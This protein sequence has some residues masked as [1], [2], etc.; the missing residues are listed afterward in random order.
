MCYLNVGRGHLFQI[1][2]PHD[3]DR[4]IHDSFRGEPIRR[5]I[6]PSKNVVW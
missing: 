1:L 2:T 6:L 5:T 4:R 3:A